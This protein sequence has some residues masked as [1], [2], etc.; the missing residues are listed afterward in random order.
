M[1]SFFS[2]FWN[3]LHSSMITKFIYLT[4]ISPKAYIFFD[5]S[6]WEFFHRYVKCNM[7]K[8]EPLVLLCIY[9]LTF[10][11][12]CKWYCYC[13]LSNF[14]NQKCWVKLSFLSSISNLS[15]DMASLPPT[16]CLNPSPISYFNAMCTIAFNSQWCAS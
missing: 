4:L 15:T 6:A 5:I 12:I 2:L 13:Y 11:L 8:S 7:S 1:S 3:S 16:Y 10:F 14:S 9:P